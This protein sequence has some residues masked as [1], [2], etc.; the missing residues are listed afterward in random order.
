MS[1]LAE[2]VATVS[3]Q[4]FWDYVQQHIFAPAGMTGSAYYTREQWLG[5]KRIAHPYMAQADGTRIDG[6]RDLDAGTVYSP[7]GGGANPARSFIGGGGGGGFSTAPDLIDN[8]HWK[9]GH[10]GGMGG[11]NTNWSVYLDTEWVGVILCN[12]DYEQQ[13]FQDIMTHERQAIVGKE[14]QG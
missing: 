13:L 4:S 8:Y 11:T 3:G 5:D 2:I 6:V 14:K 9:I 10:G 12:Y 7:S 1:A